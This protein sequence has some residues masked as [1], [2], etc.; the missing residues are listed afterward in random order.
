MAKTKNTSN[1]ARFIQEGVLGENTKLQYTDISICVVR[2][3][4]FTICGVENCG[5]LGFI[6]LAYYGDFGIDSN[7]II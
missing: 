2:L 6:C 4:H 5:D 3:L 7:I 1:C